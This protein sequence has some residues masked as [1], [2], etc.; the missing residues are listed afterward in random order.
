MLSVCF[1][2]PLP[3]ILWR[4]LSLCG[5]HSFSNVQLAFGAVHLLVSYGLGACLRLQVFAKKVHGRAQETALSPWQ[6]PLDLGERGGPQLFVC[7]SEAWQQSL[8][9]DS[10]VLFYYGMCMTP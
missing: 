10:G 2:F 8:T 4:R 6:V 7:L 9:R 3:L 1:S 5:F